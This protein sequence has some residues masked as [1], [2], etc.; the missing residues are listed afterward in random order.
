MFED[1]ASN[2]CDVVRVFIDSASPGAGLLESKEATTLSPVYMEHVFDFLQRAR[3]HGIYVIFCFDMWGPNSTW[4]HRG[5]ASS[6][7]VSGPNRNLYFRSA[8]R[9]PGLRCY[10]EFV[11]A[12]KAHD[13]TLL[14]V[15]FSYEIQ[16]ELCYFVN[17]EPLC[18]KSGVFH[19]SGKTF[20][21]SSDEGI[22]G[23]MDEVS[24]QWCNSSVEAVHRTDPSSSDRCQRIQLSRG[25]P[26]RAE[27]FA[28]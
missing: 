1:L 8:P 10:R 3:S 22:Q 11:K 6:S 20:D 15:V 2:K 14:P 16:N 9:K 23:L 27:S 5:P 13:A 17:A 7:M 26:V 24:I 12:I 28:K 21:L 18:L 25:W 19:Y 4:L